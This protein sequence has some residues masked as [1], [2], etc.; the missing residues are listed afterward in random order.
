M[1]C[2]INTINRDEPFAGVTQYKR[3]GKWEAHIWISN[4]K[5]RGYQRHLGSYNTAEDA[6]RA[7]DRATIRLRGIDDELNFPASDY[8]DD[9]FLKEHMN[10]WMQSDRQ[11]D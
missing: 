1:A 6:A 5:G 11:A 8:A 7:F 10:R 9:V 2:Q 3:T 4:P